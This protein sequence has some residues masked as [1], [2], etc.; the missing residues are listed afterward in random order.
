MLESLPNGKFA[1]FGSFHFRKMNGMQ[2]L[3]P[4]F[5][6]FTVQKSPAS[7]ATDKA[8]DLPPAKLIAEQRSPPCHHR[9]K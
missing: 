3:F 5:E 2:V 4:N 8:A 9:S 7:D 1:L 6:S